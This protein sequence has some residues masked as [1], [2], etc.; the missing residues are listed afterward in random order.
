MEAVDI[1]LE[2]DAVGH[3]ARDHELALVAARDVAQER[4]DFHFAAF[5]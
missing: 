3:C 5:E 4:A 2:A 1:G